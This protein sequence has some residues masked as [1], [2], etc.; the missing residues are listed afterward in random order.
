MLEKTENLNHAV[1]L[2]AAPEADSAQRRRSGGRPFLLLVVL[3]LLLGGIYYGIHSR[4]SAQSTLAQETITS[5]VPNVHVVPPQQNAP[6]QGLVLPGQTTAFTDTP[7][8]A[9]SSGYLKKWYADIGAQVK[10]GELLAEVETPELD[11]QLRQARADLV[12]AQANAKLA[13]I[14]AKSYPGFAE[15]AVGF[16]AGA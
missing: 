2:Q 15:V 13:G 6:S 12:T 8:Y 9:R 1:P 3:L 10:K 16:D 4:T 14:T 11:A 5:S 7:I